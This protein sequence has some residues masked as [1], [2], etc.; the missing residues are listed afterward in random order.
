MPHKTA[1]ATLCDELLP[2]AQACGVVNAV[3]INADGRMIGEAF[4]GV[5]MVKAIAAHRSLAGDTRVLMVGAGGVAR[6][7]AVA[8]GLAGIGHLAI[9]NRTPANADALADIVRRVAPACKFETSTLRDPA[10]FDIAINATPL[11]VNDDDP[12]PIDVSRI[13]ADASVVEV[14]AMPPRT[15]LLEAATARGLTVVPGNAMMLPQLELVADF[16]GIPAGH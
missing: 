9:V 12:L 6:A 1:V 10:G 5:G 11:G 16:L 8:L 4:D 15:R 2:N 3:R 13:S 7:I 14:V